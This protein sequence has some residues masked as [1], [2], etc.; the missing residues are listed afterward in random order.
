[1]TTFHFDLRHANFANIPRE[2]FCKKYW[3]FTQPIDVFT[4]EILNRL[5][6]ISLCDGTSKEVTINRG[7]SLLFEKYVSGSSKASQ[8]SSD[9]CP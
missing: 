3:T 2:L 8:Q 7:L 5:M 6:I 4:Y 1:M 9:I